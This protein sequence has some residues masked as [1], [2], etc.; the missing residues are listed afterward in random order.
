MVARGVGELLITAGIV[1]LLFVA[2]EVYVTDWISA[3][4]QREAT[5]GLDDRWS[6]PDTVDGGQRDTHY[7]LGDGEGF[8]KIFIPAF[9]PDYRFTI[10]EGTSGK[11]LASGPGHY[12]GTALPGEPGNFAVAGHRIGKGAPFRNLDRLGSCDAILVETRSDWFVYRM[13]PTREEAATWASSGLGTRP[14]CAGVAPLVDVSAPDGGPYGQTFGREIVSP[15]D[16]AVVG[17]VPNRPDARLSPAQQVALLTLTTCH[18][19]LSDKQRMII[20]A[21]LVRQWKK[22]ENQ[23]GQLPPE[24]REN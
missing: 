23:P 17:P 20:H 5:A 3:G 11:I 6:Q 21:V 19:L 16:G 10:L 12:P 1:I 14:N 2:Y 18:P 8:A 15:R 4:K 9:G 24:L 22:D 13:L 7:E